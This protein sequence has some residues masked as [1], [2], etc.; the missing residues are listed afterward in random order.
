MLKW[1][2]G[3]TYQINKFSIT[4]WAWLL[5]AGIDTLNHSTVKNKT[6]TK[7]KE[8]LVRKYFVLD[9]QRWWKYW[10]CQLS[11]AVYDKLCMAFKVLAE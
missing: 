9:R 10:L 11:A 8:A 5:F 7:H 4:G 2:L 6:K 3:A 1:D